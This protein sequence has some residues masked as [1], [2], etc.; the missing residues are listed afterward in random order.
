MGFQRKAILSGR[1]LDE[2]ICGGSCRLHSS[3]LVALRRNVS[4]THN[5]IVSLRRA[6]RVSVILRSALYPAFTYT[7]RTKR[8]ITNYSGSTERDVIARPLKVAPS[9]AFETCIVITR[10]RWDD[11]R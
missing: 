5:L 10:L 6:P 11:N 8:L 2:L 1:V 7:C 9:L 4:R 3:L